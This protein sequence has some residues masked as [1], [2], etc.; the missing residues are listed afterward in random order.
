[1]QD[2]SGSFTQYFA[3]TWPQALAE[4]LEVEIGMPSGQTTWEYLVVLL[5]LIFWHPE[6]PKGVR[7][8]GDNLGALQG[9]LHLRGRA[10]LSKITRELSWR[11]ARHQWRFS[12]GHLPTEANLTADALSRLTA[13]EGSERKQLPASVSAATRRELDVMAVWQCT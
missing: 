4:K 6:F 13:P 7:I 10:G 12:V 3:L 5:T 11:K 2:S 9:A 8:F 1:V